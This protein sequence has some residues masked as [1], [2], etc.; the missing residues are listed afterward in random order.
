VHRTA[1]KHFAAVFA[2]IEALGL[3]GVIRTCAGTFV[4]RHKG[5]DPS[6]GL[7]S[8]SWGIAIDVNVAWNGYGK[9]PAAPGTTGSVHEIVP[10]FERHGFAW[11]GYFSPPYEDGMHFELARSDP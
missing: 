5:W 1:E 10:V 7:S 4:P 11:G 6:R 3:T 2:E 8:H 9:T